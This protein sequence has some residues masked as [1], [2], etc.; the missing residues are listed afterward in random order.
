MTT[1]NKLNIKFFALN[2]KKMV[3]DS[4]VCVNFVAAI[5]TYI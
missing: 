1:N 5:Y 4:T 2:I 3:S